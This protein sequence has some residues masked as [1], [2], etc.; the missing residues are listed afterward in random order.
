MG[1]REPVSGYS[2]VQRRVYRPGQLWLL[3]PKFVAHVRFSLHLT[4]TGLRCFLVNDAGTSR[5]IPANKDL[6]LVVVGEARSIH[7]DSAS[8]AGAEGFGK[9]SPNLLCLLAA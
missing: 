8:L 4:S 1:T 6:E 5:L 7:P 9:Q 3:D 2:A